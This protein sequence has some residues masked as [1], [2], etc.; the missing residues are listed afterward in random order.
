MS[1]NRYL[2][3]G[4]MCSALTDYQHTVTQFEESSSKPHGGSFSIMSSDGS[5]KNKVM[6]NIAAIPPIIASQSSQNQGFTKL[7]NSYLS[8]MQRLLQDNVITLAEPKP[9]SDSQT[10][11]CW[12]DGSKCCHYHHVLDHDIERCYCLG[13]I[14]QDHIDSGAMKV[15]ARKHKSNKFVDKTSN[16]L[17]IYTNPF[18]PHSTNAI[19]TSD[20]ALDGGPYV[21]M[22]TIT[23]ISPLPTR[24]RSLTFLSYSH[25]SMSH[26]G[27]SLLLS[28]FLLD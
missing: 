13:H 9:L 17:H 15:N 28:I 18:P 3:F 16:D 11:P 21:N 10:Y 4:S 12:F 23:T 19:S 6:A 2:N 7:N 24:G 20:P 26:I 22:I 14:V 8:I 1:L 27:E 25:C 5:Q